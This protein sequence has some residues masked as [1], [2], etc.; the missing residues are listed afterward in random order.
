MEFSETHNIDLRVRKTREAIKN[1]FKEM[2]CEMTAEKITVKELSDRARIHRKTF[3]LH[4]TSIE[5]LYQDIMSEIA[6]GYYAEIEKI[7][8][9]YSH[10]QI[11]RVF[12][13]YY[14]KQDKFVERLICEPSYR[15]FCDKL[16][17]ATLRHNLERHNPYSKF[18]P[19][20]QN[21]INM[22]LVVSSLELYRQ[23]IAGRKKMPLEEVIELSGKLL[24]HGI[25]GIL[26]E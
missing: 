19:E 22:F 20:Q 26:K 25:S 21:M 7:P 17:A 11:N 3:Y 24:E 10:E 9:P 12:F 18:T 8:L 14:A 4:Y 16:H 5:A 23:W 6:D 1:A 13:E 15:P 2:I